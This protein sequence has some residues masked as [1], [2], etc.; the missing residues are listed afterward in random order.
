MKGSE[1]E[2]MW[3]SMA[4]DDLVHVLSWTITDTTIQNILEHTHNNCCLN[5]KSISKTLEA[6]FKTEV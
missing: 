4:K 6:Q 2:L 5:C 1:K 3:D